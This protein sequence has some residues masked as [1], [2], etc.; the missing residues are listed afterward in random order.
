[1]PLNLEI[2]IPPAKP[3]SPEGEEKKVQ[4]YLEERVPI[5]KET[6]KNILDG[7][8]FEDVMKEADAEYQPHN[9]RSES[10]KNSGTM[11]VQDE[12]KG[13]RGSR[14]VRITGE[15]G[16]EWRSDV[17]EPTLLVKIQT[18]ISIL[19]DQNPE[20]VFKALLDRYKP[21]TAI[22]T[23]IYKRSWALAQSK[24]QLKIFIF[25]LAKYGWAPGRT[26]PRLEQRQKEILQELDL[27]HPEKNKYKTVTITEF[28]D[29]YREALDP[30]R[31]WIDDMAN[32]Y[33]PFSMDDWYFEKDF[34]KDSFDLQF[35]QY[36]NSESVSF[37][38]KSQTGDNE[39]I[40]NSETKERTD[41]VTLGFYESKKKDLYSI[42]VPETSIVIYHSPLPNDEGLLSLWDAPWNIR[43]PR[44]RYGIGLYEMMKND[45]TLYDRLNNMDM[46]SLVLSIYTM[47]FYSG[48]NGLVADGVMTVSPGLIKQKL[49]GTT[50][51]Q[52]KIDY[53][54]MGREGA[55]K[56][57][58]RI[59]E[60]TG[61]TPTLQGQVE[62][63]TLGEVLHA[64]DAALKRLNIPLANIGTALEQDAYLT[65]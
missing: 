47:L 42:Y 3:Y 26:Y 49:P 65:L 17:S 14:I 16:G 62:G 18:A 43:D 51:D 63:K 32:L 13:L 10:N 12:I 11:L 54:G 22:A 46:D 27:D 55:E 34:S 35:G 25:N 33:D 24:E 7:I 58:S 45:K 61:I 1:M 60:I 59:D 53:A 23:S 48:S 36:A 31:T 5:L 56:V 29:I 15:E 8:N 20:A 44:T 4:A 64:K 30:W 2:E 39:D 9:L 28:D 21:S 19:V 41:V 52:V 38:G 57:L 40:G 6:K 37:T 50:V